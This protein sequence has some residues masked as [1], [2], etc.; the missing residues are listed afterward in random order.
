MKRCPELQN[1]SREHHSALKLT[2]HLKRAAASG[3]EARIEAACVRARDVFVNELL[4][5]FHEEEDCLLPHLEAAGANVVVARTLIEHRALQWLV[6][7][8]EVP[9]PEVLLRFAEL[10][11]EHVRFEERELFEVAEGELGREAL[12][13][14]LRRPGNA[15]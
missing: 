11:S 1:L 8:L 13:R 10:M 3:D 6:R 4:P 12:A 5:H 14:I 15:S 7:E 9:D 2:L